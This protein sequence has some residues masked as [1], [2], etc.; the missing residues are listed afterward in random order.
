L[1]D[2]ADADSAVVAGV[3]VKGNANL[4]PINSNGHIKSREQHMKQVSISDLEP[5]SEEDRKY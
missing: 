2:D 5:Y 4:N 3:Y 1:F